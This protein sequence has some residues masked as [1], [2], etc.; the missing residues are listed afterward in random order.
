MRPGAGEF[1]R[2][3]REEGLRAALEWRDGPFRREGFA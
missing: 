1:G 3:S 2:I